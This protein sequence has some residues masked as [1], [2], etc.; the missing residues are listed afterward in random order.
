MPRIFLGIGSNLGD[1][2]ASLQEAVEMISG[3]V[4][5]LKVSSL[6]ETEPV[7]Y[8][9]QPWFLNLVLEG[10]TDLLPREL[11]S[12]T[13]S[14]EQAMKRVKTIRWGPRTI[15]VDILLYEGVTMDSPELTIPHP[16]MKERNFVM[17]P[18]LEIAPEILIDG[19]PAAGILSRLNGEEIRKWEK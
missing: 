5:I 3:K 13:Q 12:F 9:D 4:R 11:L 16:R 6:Y 2:E 1:R 8:L 7:G 19:E 17:V 15:D 10:E 14:V 18:L